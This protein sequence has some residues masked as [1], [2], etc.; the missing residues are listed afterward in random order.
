MVVAKSFLYVIS[1]K[2]SDTNG[3]NFLLSSIGRKPRILKN[4]QLCEDVW[5][6]MEDLVQLKPEEKISLKND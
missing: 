5:S 3:K 6:K 2:G 1:K 4:K